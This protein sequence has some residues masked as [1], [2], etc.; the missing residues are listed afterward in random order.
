MSQGKT[1]GP[2]LSAE[3]AREQAAR[4]G[5]Q[6]EALRQNLLRRKA[7]T[8]ERT[9]EPGTGPAAPPGAPGAKD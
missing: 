5:R 7:Q 9:A 3:G 4:Q 1:K 8:R 6:A 2:K